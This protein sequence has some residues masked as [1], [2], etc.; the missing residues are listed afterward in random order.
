MLLEPSI[1]ARSNIS[2]ATSH[3]MGQNGPASSDDTDAITAVSWSPERQLIVYNFFCGFPVQP[4]SH[5]RRPY[6]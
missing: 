3:K 1:H 4:L 5:L 6:L 2:S